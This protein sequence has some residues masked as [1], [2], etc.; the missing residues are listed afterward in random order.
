[1]QVVQVCH[2]MSTLSSFAQGQRVPL[3]APGHSRNSNTAV[4]LVVDPLSSGRYLVAELLKR[5]ENLIAV[6]SSQKLPG[7]LS[8]GLE[9]D[10]E[11]LRTGKTGRF[12][13]IFDHVD[14]EDAVECDADQG[15]VDCDAELRLPNEEKD[16]DDAQFI[17]NSARATLECI[18]KAGFNVKAIVG[19]SEPGVPLAEQ[20]QAAMGFTARNSVRTSMVRRDKYPMQE[21]LR[22]TK[23]RAIKQK[24]AKSPEEVL[25]WMKESNMEFPLILKPAMGAGTEGVR[26]CSNEDDVVQ[27]FMAECASGKVNICGVQNVGLIA[28]EF[29]QG[30]EYVVDSISCGKGQHA[31]VAFWK[32]QKMSD[33]TYEYAKLIE[34]SGEVQ[35]LLR[36]YVAKVLDAVGIHFGASHAEVIVTKDGPCLVEVGARMHGGHGPAVMKDATCFGHH[37]FL[38]DLTIGC[39]AAERVHELVKKDYRYKLV[40]HAYY[41]Q[42]NNRPEWQLTGTIQEEIGEFI[43]G[44]DK[45]TVPE[46]EAGLNFVNLHPTAIQKFH[47]TL[48]KGDQLQITTDLLSSP[49]VFLV[50]N[51]SEQECEAAI[52]A[53]RKAERMMLKHAIGAIDTDTETDA[54]TGTDTETGSDYHTDADLTSTCQP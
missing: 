42:L 47:A 12:I 53:V 4:V 8:R 20:L 2:I 21:A 44:I 1:M 26:K 28:Q 48:H 33:L 32:Y 23:L 40:Q 35:D 39:Q 31:V 16:A 24:F 14:D 41:G 25:S 19:G 43:P 30:T 37:E 15:T 52:Q 45:K 6:Q 11:A 29:L 7:F 9:P 5:G 22:K 54:A 36:T 13:G 3:L 27:A 38:A 18:K 10:R 34:S 51:E 49:G 17:T 46:E 50:V